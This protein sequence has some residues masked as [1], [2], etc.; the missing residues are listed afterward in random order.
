MQAAINVAQP[1]SAREGAQEYLHH[2]IAR[3]SKS[4]EGRMLKL[5]PALLICLVVTTGHGTSVAQ[6]TSHPSNAAAPSDAQKMFEKMKS[7]A[8]SWQGTI[9]N[10]SIHV[11]IRLASSG[12]TI[13][14][15]AHTGGGRPPD[16]EITMFYVDGDRLL[17]THYCDGGNRARLEGKM[18][19]DGKTSEF[20]L[21]DVAGSTRGGLVKRMVFIMI[22]ANKHLIEL[23]FIMPNGKPV[24]LRGEFERI[25]ARAS[26]KSATL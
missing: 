18:S 14:H 6:T 17:A 10:I 24:E 20:N 12:T 26:A 11:T 8:G 3:L 25:I 19:P 4:L 21:L 23:T 15:E 16:H 13:L 2:R 9:M 22:D 1:D 7:L 5:L